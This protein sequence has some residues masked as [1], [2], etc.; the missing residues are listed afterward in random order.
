[1]SECDIL[2]KLGELEKVTDDA[3]KLK[4]MKAQS[5]LDMRQKFEE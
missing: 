4:E 3:A 2:K 5:Q 1:M